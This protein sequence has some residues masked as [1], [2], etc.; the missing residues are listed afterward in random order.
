MNPGAVEETADGPGD[1][2][3]LLRPAT[4]CECTKNRHRSTSEEPV[5]DNSPGIP[6]TLHRDGQ[7]GPLFFGFSEGPYGVL[8]SSELVYVELLL[9]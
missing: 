3:H 7:L 2:G 8:F 6:D 5:H 4:D 9:R 1:R